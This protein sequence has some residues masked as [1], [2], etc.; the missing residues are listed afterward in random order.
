MSIESDAIEATWHALKG[1][2][3]GILITTVALVL[4]GKGEAGLLQ[5]GIIYFASLWL[6]AVMA[7]GAAKKRR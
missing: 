3:A 2:I 6:T 5:V 7:M 4:I 1:G